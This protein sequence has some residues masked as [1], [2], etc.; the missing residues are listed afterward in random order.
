[1]STLTIRIQPPTLNEILTEVCLS[2][3]QGFQE[4]YL[5]NIHTHQPMV[6]TIKRW[7]CFIASGYGY[8]RKQI[9]P[10]IGSDT[11]TSV[12]YYREVISAWVKVYDKEKH[13]FEQLISRLRLKEKY[14]I[15]YEHGFFYDNPTYK[16]EDIFKGGVKALPEITLIKIYDIKGCTIRNIADYYPL[17][18]VEDY[19]KLTKI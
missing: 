10:Y 18:R 5:D 9:G 8:T 4:W 11:G 13:T 7:V 2:I 14:N 19:F 12:S 3:N 16:V 17:E 6:I 15:T 1:M